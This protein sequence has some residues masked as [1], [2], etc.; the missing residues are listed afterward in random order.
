MHRAIAIGLFIVLGI[1]SA[2]RADEAMDALASKAAR[3]VIEKFKDEKI[4]D[5]QLAITFIDLRDPANPRAGN[6]RGDQPMYPASVV[7]L[8]YLV[9][10][11]HWLEDGKLKDSDELQRTLRDMIVDSSNDATAMIVDALSDAINGPPLPETEMA[12]WIEKRN[13]MNQYFASLGYPVG[14]PNGIHVGQKTYA[15]GPYGR[16]RLF[17]SAPP[18]NRNRLTT[19]VTAKLMAQIALGKAVSPERSK[20]ML[21]LLKRDPTTKRANPNNQA[22]G[23]TAGGLP[24]GSQLWSKAGWINSHRHDAAYVETP[25]GLKAVIVTFTTQHSSQ[26]QI[27]PTVARSIL[28]GLKN[29]KPALTPT[30]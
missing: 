14:G 8:F 24:K 11:H 25:D 16:E 30:P 7:K 3:D 17:I 28:E 12:T 6:F 4:A 18:G 13:R 21:E 23:Y 10:T 5:D 19:D 2:V 26:R 9:A 29:I 20:Q 27:I 15:E 22:T 1:T